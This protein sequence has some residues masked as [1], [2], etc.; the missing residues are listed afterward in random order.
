VAFVV[1]LAAVVVFG[2]V[3]TG[4]VNLGLMALPVLFIVSARLVFLGEAAFRGVR[5]TTAQG[6]DEVTRRFRCQAI[7]GMLVGLV[8]A[9]Y[10]LVLM[11][12]VEYS[13]ILLVGCGLAFIARTS[14]QSRSPSQPDD[15]ACRAAACARSARNRLR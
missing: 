9:Y 12:R 10:G 14:R 5:G 8:L 4:E 7:A 2:F 15:P 3:I 13:A 6:G 11:I 1:A